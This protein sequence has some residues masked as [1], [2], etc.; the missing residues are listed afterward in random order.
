MVTESAA[1]APEAEVY[2]SG[3]PFVMFTARDG[4]GVVDLF[5]SRR[6]AKELAA[7]LDHH[8]DLSATGTESAATIR[9]EA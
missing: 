2:T 3:G 5:L 8:A 9:L 6:E 4:T 7:A 1:Y